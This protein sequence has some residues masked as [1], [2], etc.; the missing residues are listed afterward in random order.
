MGYDK[1][2][3]QRNDSEQSPY[4][5]VGRALGMRNSSAGHLVWQG[6][7]GSGAGAAPG[8]EHGEEQTYRQF[9]TT[10]QVVIFVG[11]LLGT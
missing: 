11:S 3:M 6:G 7:N 2:W 9:T 4:Q 1:S 8:E 5:A 10:V